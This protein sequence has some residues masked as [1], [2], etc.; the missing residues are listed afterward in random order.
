MA[1]G[2][3]HMGRVLLAAFLLGSLLF[4]GGERAARGYTRGQGLLSV[5]QA[6]QQAQGVR[7]VLQGYMD[8][9]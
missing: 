8:R 1:S 7:S 4:F 6:E 5:E 3:K 9:T 2:G